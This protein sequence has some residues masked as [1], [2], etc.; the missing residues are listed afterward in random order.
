MTASIVFVDER[1]VD[2]DVLLAGFSPEIEVVLLDAEE[3]GIEQIAATLAGAENL[4]A[5]HIVSHGS[6]GLLQLGA[7]ALSEANLDQYTEELGEIGNALSPTGDLLL[8]GCDV[9]S[10]DAGLTFIGSLS[11][12]TK[13]DV[14]ASTDLTG[15]AALGGDWVLEATAVAT[16]LK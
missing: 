8:Y 13:A 10:G 11:E 2:L 1:V 7:T 15:A 4:S 5:I 14:A 9:A 6:P 12:W 16:S 3:D